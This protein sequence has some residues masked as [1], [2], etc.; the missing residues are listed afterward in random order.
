MSLYDLAAEEEMLE[1]VDIFEADVSVLED[2][3][4]IVSVLFL[5]LRSG[6]GW[7]LA[8]GLCPPFFTVVTYGT[9]T[10]FGS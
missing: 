2:V 5:L 10:G 8:E 1:P 4:E 9:F 6:V 7:A 3:T